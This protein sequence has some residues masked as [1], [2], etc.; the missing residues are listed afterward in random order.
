MIFSMSLSSNVDCFLYQRSMSFS[1]E[2]KKCARKTCL[3]DQLF[4]SVFYR[5]FLTVK[6]WPDLALKHLFN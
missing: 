1:A 4:N 5:I 3:Y 2:V 6:K